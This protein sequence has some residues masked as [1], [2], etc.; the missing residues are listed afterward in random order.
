MYKT[1]QEWSFLAARPANL[2]LLKELHKYPDTFW[3]VQKVP[4]DI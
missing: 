1:I 4:I 3:G 2:G